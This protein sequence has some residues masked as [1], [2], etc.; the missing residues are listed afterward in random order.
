MSSV[1]IRVFVENRFRKS[2]LDIVLF[3]FGLSLT[4]SC[5]GQKSSAKDSVFTFEKGRITLTSSDTN[6][7]KSFLWAKR[8]ALAYVFEG[9]PVG[10]WYEAALP[11]REAFCMRDVS[12]QSMGANALGLWNHN[13]NMLRKFAENI[14]D[15]K[16]W[17]TP[18]FIA[19]Y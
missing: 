6:L 19:F 15:S 8:Q 16:D 11:K 10:D 14:S 1:W 7:V 13:K 9:D 12:H 4:L 17:C 3:I 2:M 5:S 18:D